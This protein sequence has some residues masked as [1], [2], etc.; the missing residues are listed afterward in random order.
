[1]DGQLINATHFTPMA[2]SMQNVRSRQC[3][4]CGVEFHYLVGK[5]NDRIVC[6]Q[7]CRD[8]R[9]LKQ[10]AIRIA[11][12][13]ACSVAECDG[14]ATRRSSGMCE[15]HYTRLRRSGSV[16]VRMAAYRYVTASGYVKL[17]MPD[18]PLAEGSSG[19]VAEHRYVA[20]QK[21]GQAICCHWCS[22]RLSWKSAV[23]DHLNDI[24]SD[25]RPDNLVVACNNCNRARGAILPFLASLTAESLE[26]FLYHARRYAMAN[27]RGGE[28]DP[29]H[30]RNAA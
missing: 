2:N 22:I 1:M 15:M 8:A 6:S 11:A 5:G 23:V 14:K 30:Q 24:K 20:Y 25:N 21:Y 7:T 27:P 10:R 4:Q 26:D 19:A 16:Q 3:P 29:L 13:P 18:H 9:K 28:P 17:L 12:L